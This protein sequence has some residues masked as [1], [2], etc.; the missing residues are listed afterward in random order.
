MAAF[1]A[2]RD[3]LMDALNTHLQRTASAPSLQKY[4]H[5]T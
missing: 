2:H 5:L 4:P 3:S 1:Q